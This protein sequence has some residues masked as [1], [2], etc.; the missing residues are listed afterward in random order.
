MANT[1]KQETKPLHLA[2]LHVH[3]GDTVL[4]L[5]G[6][7]RGKR[8]TVQRAM[9][10]EN[11]VIVEGINIAKKHVKAGRGMQ[12]GIIEKA[13]PLHASN[14]MVICTECGKPTRI[15]HERVPQGSDQKERVRRVCKQCGQPIQEHTRD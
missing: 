6:K 7:D 8:G 2:K 15:G 1:H 12:A 9:P 13:M 5:T 11:K 4:V 14:V 10:R 3:K